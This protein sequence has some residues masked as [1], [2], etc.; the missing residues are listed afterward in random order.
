LAKMFMR[1]LVK[2]LAADISQFFSFKNR[3]A[4]RPSSL[5]LAR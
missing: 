5:A 2:R 1:H 3:D 4:R